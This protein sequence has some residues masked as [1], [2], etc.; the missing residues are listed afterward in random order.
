MTS[1]KHTALAQ[2]TKQLLEFSPL[3]LFFAVY[4]FQG[5]IW[6]TAA[7]VLA[8]LFSMAVIYR[9]EKKLSNIQIFTTALVVIFGGLTVALDDPAFLKIKV[10]LVNGIFAVVLLGGLPFG[11]LFIRDLL[12]SAVAMP[13]QAWRTL[14]VR[15]ALFFAGLAI[16]NVFVWYTFSE[17][18]WATFKFIGLIAL[19]VLFALANAP[20]MARHMTVDDDEKPSVN[21]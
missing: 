12:G 17:T 2:S 20:F 4:W 13:D 15:W 18:V 7:L 16:L 1:E 6:A 3:V 14:T 10:S 8:T 11:R 21:G 9:Y 5:F 19:T